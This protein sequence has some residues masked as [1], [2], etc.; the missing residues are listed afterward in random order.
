MFKTQGYKVEV[1][2]ICSIGSGVTDFLGRPAEQGWQEKD[3]LHIFLD[4]PDTDHSFDVWKLTHPPAQVDT[5]DSFFSFWK[6]FPKDIKDQLKASA[7]NYAQR[8]TQQNLLAA[9][10]K[11]AYQTAAGRLGNYCEYDEAGNQ[12]HAAT[13]L[14]P[15]DPQG[16]KF[17][18]YF[19]DLQQTAF[20]EVSHAV[21]VGLPTMGLSKTDNYLYN[22]RVWPD[23]ARAA[24]SKGFSTVNTNHYDNDLIDPLQHP[25]PQLNLEIAGQIMHSLTG[26]KTSRKVLWSVAKQIDV[27][28]KA[29]EAV[30]KRAIPGQVQALNYLLPLLE[31]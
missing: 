21:L 28:V 5:R 13:A 11:L 22:Q 16:R 10:V 18:E 4:Q 29:M 1:K 2:D 23:L 25:F 20:D 8:Q 30:L 14:S 6:H 27:R 19:L 9:V 26:E 17:F 12:L 31:I 3:T 24:Q 15:L 7:A